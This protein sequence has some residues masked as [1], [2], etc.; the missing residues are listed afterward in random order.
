[1][2]AKH[3]PETVLSTAEIRDKMLIPKAVSL[4]V[5]AELAKGGFIQTF[6]GRDGGIKLARPASQ[7]NLLQ[8]VSHFE[9]NFIIS[10]CTQANGVCPFEQI[11]PIRHSWAR[12]QKT[13]EAELESTTFEALGQD[14]LALQ[15]NV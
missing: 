14:A 2:L 1:A 9:T 3:P 6:P 10:E 11:C 4:R 5:V 7:I 8:V 15:Q 12:L 13:I